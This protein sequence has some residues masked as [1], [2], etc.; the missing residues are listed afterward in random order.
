[1]FV[2]VFSRIKRPALFFLI[3]KNNKSFA[4]LKKKRNHRLPRIGEA[5][6]PRFSRL[7]GW[8]FDGMGTGRLGCAR[9]CDAAP[10][11]AKCVVF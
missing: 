1:M 6:K 3:N 7:A 2:S 11:A 10:T 5:G 4:S 8:H 9:A